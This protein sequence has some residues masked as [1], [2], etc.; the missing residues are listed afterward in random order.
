MKIN[1]KNPQQVIM[2]NKETLFLICIIL[3]LS[4]V[5]FYD[6][7]KTFFQQDEWQ[8]FGANIYS[9][10]T[11]HPILFTILPFQ[12]QLTH[13]FPFATLFFLFEYLL[14]KVNFVPYV[15]IGLGLHI[16]NAFLSF[17][18][19]KNISKN[20]LIAFFSSGFFL[21]NSISHQPVTWIAAG[22]G[23]L[24]S[25]TS[26]LLSIFFFIKYLEKKEI[27]YFYLVLPFVV[28][29][30]LF[31]EVSVFIFIILPIYWIFYSKSFRKINFKL[32]ASFLSVGVVYFLF[33]LL[34]IF[35][36][37]RSPQPEIGEASSASTVDSIPVYLFRVFEIP[38]KGLAQLF[39]PQNFLISISDAIV[40][41]AYPQF[42]GSDG[43]VNPYIS[44]SIVFGLT[45]YI[46]SVCLM[47]GGV[48]L[49]YFFKTNKKIHL[50]N[51]VLFS[52]LLSTTSLLPFI[53]IPGKPGYFSIFES[54]NLY[55]GM[56]GASILLI[57]F[58]YAIANYFSNKRIRF[59]VVLF[60]LLPLFVFHVRTVRSEIN[61]LVTIATIRINLLD[62]IKIEYK[63]LSKNV[64]FYT[65]SNTSYYG[66]PEAEKT[67]PVQSGFGR[68]VMV[69]YQDAEK[70]P[71]CF[72]ENQ[73]LHDL[74][75]QGYKYCEGRGFGYFRDYGKLIASINEN[76][77]PVENVIGYSWDGDTNE[78]KNIS[79]QIKKRLKNDIGQ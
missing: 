53:F 36:Q 1:D 21:I 3:F 79:D 43:A 51:T 77:I 17:F 10:S 52:F 67:L 32:L 49:F 69:W 61:K 16:L 75:S 25:T 31:K 37:I 58:V 9:L 27:K 68:M 15:L 73:F 59:V 2:N 63:T 60:F 50:A 28:I 70:F 12:G 39:F 18:L 54:R 72:Y 5:T 11:E 20:K 66:M 46:L 45:C 8:Y 35:F 44:Q 41:L 38:F 34:L 24:P 78:F 4:Y 64:V 22:I 74:T 6:L 42:V 57:L 65:Q 26:L 76:K 48:L 71:D 47:I 40:R 33:R 13:F 30:L 62:T 56:I 29:S 14:F 55:I 23:T 19:V 7:S